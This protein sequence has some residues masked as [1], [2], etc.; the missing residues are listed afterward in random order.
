MNIEELNQKISIIL[1]QVREHSV[2]YNS[3]AGR[4]DIV[5]IVNLIAEP[6]RYEMVYEPLLLLRTLFAQCPHELKR[7][8]VPLLL[9]LMTLSDAMVIAHAVMD[10]GGLR[11]L[12]PYIENFKLFYVP[13][14]KALDQKLAMESHIFN[15]SDLN[16]I[17]ETQATLRK[18]RLNEAQ[19][20]PGSPVWW[21][22]R[23]KD[24]IARVRYLRLKKELFEGQNPEINTDKVSLLSRMEALGFRGKIA[25]VLEEAEKKLNTA[26]TAF[27]FKGAMDL[28]RTAYEETFE[29]AAKVI[30][31]FKNKSIPT[32]SHFKPFREFLVNQS[33]LT[34]DEGE[35]SQKLY[36]YLSN[37]GSHALGSAPEQARVERT[38]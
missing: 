36:N 8:F 17:E 6:G 9:S 4:L 30:A 33:I 37:A 3:M 10:A 11:R 12:R 21:L 1:S 19:P 35:V 7:E 16:W 20:A 34:P 15:E 27:D 13:M 38:L 32:G 26:T 5:E 23:L 14:C 2:I 25:E 24:R 29:D 22:A 18:S 28:V 31:N